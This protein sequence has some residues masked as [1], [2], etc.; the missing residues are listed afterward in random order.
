MQ[1]CTLN[2]NLT[3]ALPTLYVVAP[4]LHGTFASA[5][6]VSA[7]RNGTPS[8]AMAAG[9]GFGDKPAEA[10]LTKKTLVPVNFDSYFETKTEAPVQTPPS[11]PGGGPPPPSAG[12]GNDFL[13]ESSGKILPE[14]PTGSAG[15]IEIVV[16]MQE[17]QKLDISQAKSLLEPLL[18]TKEGSRD[19]MTKTVG[20]KIEY[21]KQ[22]DF[23]PREL[24]EIPDVRLWFLRLDA[25]YPWLPCVL[26]WRAG[27]MARYA[28]M[29]TPHQISVKDGLVFNPEG[30]ELFINLKLFVCFKWL[31]SVE[32]KG[33]NQ[34]L[35][36]MMIMLGFSL[37]ESLFALM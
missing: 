22:D 31:K 32:A 6:S 11:A 12:G 30:I 18:A 25:E 20:F 2:C 1:N 13:A 37:D 9:K 26:D 16:T 33:A 29:L 4:K 21:E 14:A 36:D 34:K 5:R 17:L 23:D 10:K 8:V 15:R 24:C 7:R 28:A 35:K 27:E 3:R 19:L